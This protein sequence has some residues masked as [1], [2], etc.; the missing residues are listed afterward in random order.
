M[1]IV[2]ATSAYYVVLLYMPTYAKAQLGLP[3]AGASL[4][5]MLALGWMIAL[6]PLFGMLSDRIGRRP[7]IG[8]A[9][10][11]FFLLPY[12]L[13]AWVQAQPSFGRLLGLQLTMCGVVAI[14]A[15]GPLSTTLAEQFPTRVRST[16]MAIAYNFAVML[17]G[18][19]AP[20]IITWLIRETGSRSA[21]A[22]YIMF[23]AA[24]GL[25]ASFLLT[26]RPAPTTAAATG[27]PLVRQEAKA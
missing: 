5:Q 13:F 27:A 12:P 10:L 26:E 4:A 8:A 9:A 1:L 11:G 25:A 21:P 22:F 18:G 19:F 2:C 16:G 3:L 6:I 7:V 24:A 14:L 17:F 23:G 20:F 15:T